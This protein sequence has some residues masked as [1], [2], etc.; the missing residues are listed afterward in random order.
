MTALPFADSIK[1]GLLAAG[2]YANRLGHDAFPGVLGLC[3]HGIRESPADDDRI[4]FANLHVLAETFDELCRMIAETW[5][6]GSV[7]R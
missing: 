7:G 2:W 3:Y 4:P 5:T 6:S 1:T